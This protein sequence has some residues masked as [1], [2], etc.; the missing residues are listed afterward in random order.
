MAAAL[1]QTA[2]LDK[3]KEQDKKEKEREQ[4]LAAVESVSVL[5]VS[6]IFHLFFGIAY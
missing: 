4:R 6:T 2:S 3:K 5:Q 1:N